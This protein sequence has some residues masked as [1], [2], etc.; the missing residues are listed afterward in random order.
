[1]IEVQQVAYHRNGV[2]GEAVYV[3]LVADSEVVA[4]T[5]PGGTLL[6]L[7]PAWA[8]DEAA[9]ALDAA[10]RAPSGGIP[11]YAVD[12]QLAAAGEVA[13]GAN[14][15]RGEQYYTA[16]RAAVLTRRSEWYAAD[17]PPEVLA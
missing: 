10:K 6:V 16:V 8:I 15:W 13:F 14:S 3:A 11:C 4:S 9:S 1:M 17:C 5:R 7:V 12:P 2:G